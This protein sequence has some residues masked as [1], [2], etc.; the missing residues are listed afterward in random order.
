MVTYSPLHHVIGHSSNGRQVYGFLTRKNLAEVIGRNPRILALIKE[1]VEQKDLTLAIENLQ[2][3]LGRAIGYSEVIKT[4]ITD[5][6]FYAQQTKSGDYTRFVKHRK[7]K[8]TSF[9]SFVLARDDNDNY[10]LQQVAFGKRSA[11][12]PEESSSEASDK[13]WAT[14]AVV[15]NGQPI[16]TNTV[17]KASPY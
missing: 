6:I 5:D 2:H 1:I 12:L 8:P 9:L 4:E 17:Q 13:Y 14:H 7:A 15:Y 11:P 3:D 16:Q 10:E